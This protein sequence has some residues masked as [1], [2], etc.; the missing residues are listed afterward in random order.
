MTVRT[1][2]ADPLHNAGAARSMVR[3][4]EAMADMAGCVQGI[5]IDYCYLIE[6]RLVARSCT[7]EIS[8]SHKR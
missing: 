8:A 1:E 4:L 2:L 6:A 7:S 5:E 3:E